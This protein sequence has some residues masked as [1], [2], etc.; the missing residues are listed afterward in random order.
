M[1]THRL[2]RIKISCAD[3]GILGAFTAAHGELHTEGKDA[4]GIK[5]PA[6]F[7]CM[8]QGRYSP[9]AVTMAI[10]WVWL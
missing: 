10:A 7:P 4:G 1:K 9:I 3:G 5:N 6:S 8:D 2:V